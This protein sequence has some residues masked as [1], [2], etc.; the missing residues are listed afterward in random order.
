MGDHGS[1]T[2][3]GGV[4]N[5]NAITNVENAANPN[6]NDASVGAGSPTYSTIVAPN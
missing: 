3:T 1:D 4:A 2:G 5:G 6:T